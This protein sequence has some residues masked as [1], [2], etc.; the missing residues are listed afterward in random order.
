MVAAPRSQAGCSDHNPALQL[1]LGALSGGPT[2]PDVLASSPVEIIEVD[3]FD[4]EALRKWHDVYLRSQ[5]HERPHANPWRLAEVRPEM[6]DG[7]RRRRLSGFAGLVDGAI[8]TTGSLS[9]PMLDNRN[10]ASLEVNTDPARRGEGAGSAM[11]AHLEALAAANDRTLVNTD[12]A[13]PISGSADG[14]GHANADFLTR[15]GYRFVLGDLHNALDLPLD[16]ELLADL[17]GGAEPHHA[18]YRI[19]AFTGPVPDEIV[20][21]FAALSS[22]LMTEAP[23]GE[24]E[25]EPESAEVGAYRELEAA[26]VRQGRTAY[27]SVG[28]DPTGEVVAYTTLVVSRHDPGRAYQWGTLVRRDHR[29]HRLGV[30][31]KVA[32]L[33]Q[34]QQADPSVRHLFTY[35]AEV[36]AHMAAINDALGFR[37]VERLGEFQKRLG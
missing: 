22:S 26:A 27:Q 14:V 31:V 29:G 28:L 36:N 15:R 34:L 11:L 1:F 4:D 9:L 13:Y 23:V 18:D 6:Q 20:T 30:A 24:A 2:G 35:N 17:A 7:G 16:Q 32:N 3:P 8:V 37:P 21:S 10:A 33:V 19:E 12:T 25:R 5:R